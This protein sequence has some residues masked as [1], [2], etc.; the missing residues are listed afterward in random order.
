MADFIEAPNVRGWFH[1]PVPDSMVGAVALTHGAGTGSDAPL[2]VA[3]ADALSERGHAVLRYDLSFRRERKP[4]TGAQ[5]PR[6]REGIRKAVAALRNLAP[7]VPL[8]LAG[9]SYGGRQSSIL[10]AEAEDAGI[11]DTLLLLSYPLHP[12]KQP[13]KLRTEHFPSLRIP[14]LFVHGTRDE[15]GTIAEMEAALKSISARVELRSVEK[16]PHGLASKY[17]GQ[18][19]EWFTTFTNKWV[20]R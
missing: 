4:P 14:A 15:F 13:E 19:A 12:P 2:L 3:V 9:H 18:I 5:Q 10:A 20:M 7:G 1:R 11:A 16:A 8:Y 17:A 6:D